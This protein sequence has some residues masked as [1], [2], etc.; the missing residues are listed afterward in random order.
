VQSASGLRYLG[1]DEPASFRA[2]DREQLESIL[3]PTHFVGAF[4]TT[5][6]AIDPRPIAERLRAAVLTEPRISF[7]GG[8]RV[9]SVARLHRHGFDV[10]FTQGAAQRSGPYDQVVNALWDGRLAIDRTLGIAPGRNWIFRHKF[11]NRVSVALRASDLPSVTMVLGPFGDIVNFGSAGFY[12]SWYPSGMVA[13]SRDVQPAPGWSHLDDA[14]RMEVFARSFDTWST[15]CPKLRDLAFSST[16][17]DPSSGT[18]FAWGDTDIDDPHSVLHMRDE[19]GI[20]SISGYHSVNSG[21][22]TMVP[23][24][25]LN[26]A[27]RVLGHDVV[28]RG[29]SEAWAS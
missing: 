4:E 16:Q 12:L 14:A 3:D 21:K 24:Y 25:A 13:T 27:A 8:C 5:E 18:I 26:A 20:Q 9:D 6:R 29:L 15:Y 28:T 2:L 17:V 1:R 23:Y 22:Y 19:I 7:H 11:G 10:C